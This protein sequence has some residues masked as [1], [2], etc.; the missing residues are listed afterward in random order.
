MTLRVLEHVADAD[1]RLVAIIMH[2]MGVTSLVITQADEDGMSDAIEGQ[3]LVLGQVPN[4]D[5]SIE[6]RVVDAADLPD[7]VQPLN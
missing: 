2:K 3:C 5:G 1:A 6:L 4:G 7:G